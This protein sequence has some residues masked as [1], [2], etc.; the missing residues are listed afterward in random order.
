MEK[1]YW[2]TKIR[3]TDIN[4]VYKTKTKKRYDT[5]TCT[6]HLIRNTYF[7][8]SSISWNNFIW[9]QPHMLIKKKSFYNWQ[10]QQKLS[11]SL[12]YTNHVD[13]TTILFIYSGEY[14]FNSAMHRTIVMFTQHTYILHWSTLI[15][16]QLN[17]IINIY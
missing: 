3:L 11:I 9:S 15:Y 4:T 1:P 10:K 13:R 16:K 2:E 5:F 14:A 8:F 6:R 7:G 12:L 17:T